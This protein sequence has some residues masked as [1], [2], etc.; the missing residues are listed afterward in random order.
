M[1]KLPVNWSLRDR[2]A[3]KRLRERKKGNPLLLEGPR[4]GGFTI[5]DG[6][7][8]RLCERKRGVPLLLEGGSRGG[9]HNSRRSFMATTE[10]IEDIPLLLG[11]SRGDVQITSEL[12]PSHG[13]KYVS[14]AKVFLSC[15]RGLVGGPSLFGTEL[16]DS[17]CV[18]G[19]KVFHSCL[20]GARGWAFTTN[21][22][23]QK[24]GLPANWDLRDGAA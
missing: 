19:I 21:P 1:C 22:R 17:N 20:R 24:K 11:G 12:G 23:T 4:E 10:R 6:A 3:W 15:S 7:A 18:S 2:T 16:H 9:F 8:W 14:G 13:S 5:W